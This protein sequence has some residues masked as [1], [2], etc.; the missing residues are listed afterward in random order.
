QTTESGNQLPNRDAPIYG[1]ILIHWMQQNAPALL[2]ATYGT[3]KVTFQ[4]A[5]DA[6]K[7][8]PELQQRVFVLDNVYF[9]ELTQTSIPTGAS[10]QNY[11]RGYIAINLLFPYSLGY[12]QN[13]LGGGTNGANQLVQTGNLDLRLAAI[14]SMWGGNV[15]ILGPGGRALIGSTVAT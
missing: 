3:L 4:Q 2:E 8:L 9:N 15:Y 5:Y 14:E 11:S 12:T 1:P 6:F 7:T 13:N 10:Y